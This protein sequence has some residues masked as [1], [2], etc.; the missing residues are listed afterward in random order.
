MRRAQPQHCSGRGSACGRPRPQPGAG[1]RLR[2]ARGFDS[3]VC[4][5][6]QLD[7]DIRIIASDVSSWDDGAAVQ[8]LGT[9]GQ[10]QAAGPARTRASLTPP[11]PPARAAAA[12]Q[13]DGTLVNSRQE[14]TDG[15][16]SAVQRAA[17]AG[18]PVRGRG[19]PCA[20]AG[21]RE[22]PR[23]LQDGPLPC[24]RRRIP[25]RPLWGGS[26]QERTHRPLHS[27]AAVRGDGQGAR[28]V[29]AGRAAAAGPAD[30]WRLSAGEPAAAPALCGA[31]SAAPLRSRGRIEPGWER[32]SG[33]GPGGGGEGGGTRGDAL[34]LADLVCTPPGAPHLR[35]RGS[36]AVLKVC[37][38]VRVSLCV[39]VRACACAC[40]H[41]SVLQAGLPHGRAC[42][43]LSAAHA[44]TPAC[45]RHTPPLGTATCAPHSPH[46][47]RA[48]AF[49]S[50][51]DDVVLD[52]A[53]IARR[54][55]VTLA[56]YSDDRILADALDAQTD[57]L[58]FYKVGGRTSLWRLGFRG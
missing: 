46:P 48:R 33:H 20:A 27:H 21:A 4:S 23:G 6:A 44:R 55:G 11:T 35:C 14:L 43:D 40:V 32:A 10:A 45:E 17:A 2:R 9:A 30:A 22:R 24:C 41:V 8:P 49:R 19:G 38:C 52:C 28:P 53:A 42:V 29:G 1:A 50:L 51:P 7:P 5:R 37:G 25:Q 31:A 47:A 16:A 18:V 39:C 15:V 36:H 58:L 56:A 13:V 26:W 3:G 12:M 54:A 57:R 34:K